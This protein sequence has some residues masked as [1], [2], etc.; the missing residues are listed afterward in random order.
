LLQALETRNLELESAHDSLSHTSMRTAESGKQ[1]EDRLRAEIAE[2]ERSKRKFEDSL[3]EW[4]SILDSMR[5]TDGSSGTLTSLLTI[6]L[7][8]LH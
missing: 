5:R 7:F 6:Q 4:H 1:I 8:I 2:H 3:R